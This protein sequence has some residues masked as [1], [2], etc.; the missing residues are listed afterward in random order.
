[1]T[2]SVGKRLNVGDLLHLLEIAVLLI[3]I[4]VAYEKFTAAAD[5]VELQ[6]AQLNRVEHYLSSKDPDYWRLSKETQ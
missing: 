6:R 5:Q 1:M 3:S 2:E 4:G